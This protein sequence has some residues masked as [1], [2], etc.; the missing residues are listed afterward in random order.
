MMLDMN[1]VTVQRIFRT[2]LQGMDR[3]PQ[4]NTGGVRNVKVE[5]QDTT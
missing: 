1:A 2:Q 3:A 4:L 5:H